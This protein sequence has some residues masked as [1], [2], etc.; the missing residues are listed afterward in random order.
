[1]LSPFQR[2]FPDNANAPAGFP[3]RSDTPGISRDIPGNLQMPEILAGFWP[4]K[5]VTAVSM[6]ETA[7]DEQHGVPLGEHHVGLSG[8]GS[9]NSETKASRVKGLAEEDFRL[10]V[11]S[12][13]AGHHPA[14]YFRRNDV[15]HLPRG[16]VAPAAVLLAQP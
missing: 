13:D 9:V 6:P 10:R 11:L 1:M 3:Q 15:S 2:T 16:G 5:E 7:M 12:P 8:K 14:S 4:L